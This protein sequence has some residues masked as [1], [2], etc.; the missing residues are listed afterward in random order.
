MH[1]PVSK[2]RVVS[3]HMIDSN[4]NIWRGYDRIVARSWLSLISSF[5]N[6]GPAFTRSS[7]AIIRTA[8]FTTPLIGF[9][10]AAPGRYR[11]EHH[12]AR[13]ETVSASSLMWKTATGISG[14]IAAAAAIS[15]R[16]DGSK[17]LFVG[18]NN[19][20]LRPRS[21]TK[22]TVRFHPRHGLPSPA[23][24]RL[25]QHDVC[26]TRLRSKPSRN[27]IDF[28]QGQFKAKVS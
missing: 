21:T 18:T 22:M 28:T 23:S 6:C 8:R 13:G 4:N 10:P 5:E 26:R 15:S 14:N 24:L 1:G 7:A 2:S 12:E 3:I 16:R 17:M 25:N 27:F 20:I 11:G 9:A 19:A